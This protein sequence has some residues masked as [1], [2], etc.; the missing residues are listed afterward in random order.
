[1]PDFF[2]LGKKTCGSECSSNLGVWAYDCCADDKAKCCGSVTLGGWIAAGG[3][4]VILILIILLLLCR[5][6]GG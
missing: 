2:P 1:M 4:G 5:R 6:K 3:L